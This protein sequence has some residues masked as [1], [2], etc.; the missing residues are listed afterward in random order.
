MQRVRAKEVPVVIAR[1]QRKGIVARRSPRHRADRLSFGPPWRT[2][3]ALVLSLILSAALMA[4]AVGSGHHAWVAWVSLVPLFAVI[5]IFSPR[6]AMVSGAL[7]GLS[8]YL[9]LAFGTDVQGLA[10]IQALL[11]LTAVPSAYAYLGALLT[12][13]IGF[14]PLFLALGWIGVELALRPLGFGEGLLAGSQGD[15]WLVRLPASLLGYGLV[16]FLVAYVNASLLL[17]LSS[18]CSRDGKPV[19][20]MASYDP[21][22]CIGQ[23]ISVACSSFGIHSSQ[24]RAPPVFRA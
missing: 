5:R 18:V 13:R 2:R 14:A 16:A 23:C 15:G 11:L 21:L 7:W 4:V 22:G 20:V 12:R 3:A 9:F 10:T 1:Y 24:A 17:V 19:S 6:R 8:F